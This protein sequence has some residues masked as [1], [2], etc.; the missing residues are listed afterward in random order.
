VLKFAALDDVTSMRVGGQHFIAVKIGIASAVIEVQVRV[1]D[2]V[3]FVSG[4]AKIEK[5]GIEQRRAETIDLAEFGA[6]FVTG[7][8]FDEDVFAAGANEKAI[9][10]KLNAVARVG[11]TLLFPERLGNDAE[12][13]AAIQP[14]VAGIQYVELEFAEFQGQLPNR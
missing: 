1:D 5:T 6:E 7:S 9:H 2:D 3:N 11:G 10:G 13:G 12:H 14:N 8:G 4:E